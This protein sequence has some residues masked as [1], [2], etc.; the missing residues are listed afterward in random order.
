MIFILGLHASQHRCDAYIWHG[1]L[2]ARGASET[3]PRR[4]CRDRESSCD[5]A[6]HGG[7]CKTLQHSACHIPWGWQEQR[8]PPKDMNT[9]SFSGTTLAQCGQ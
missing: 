1:S 2:G 6:Q 8:K 9:P 7:T 3:Y 5:F 4:Q